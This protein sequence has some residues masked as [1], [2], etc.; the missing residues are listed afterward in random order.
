[1]LFLKKQKDLFTIK[2]TLSGS[3][4]P[5]SQQV[6]RYE[7]YENAKTDFYGLVSRFKHENRSEST[8]TIISLFDPKGKILANYSHTIDEDKFMDLCPDTMKGGR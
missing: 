8:Y 2:M 1:M 4:R 6:K 7:H 3:Q 5:L